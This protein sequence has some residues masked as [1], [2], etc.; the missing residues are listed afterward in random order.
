MA[1]H[2]AVLKDDGTIW[3]VKSGTYQQLGDNYQT[4][5]EA[6]KIPILSSI[7]GETLPTIDELKKEPPFSFIMYC[8]ES[9]SSAVKYLLNGVADTQLVTPA[10]LINTNAYPEIT[11]ITVDSVVPSGTS[12][13]IAVTNNL[14]KY[15]I[16]D[17]TN[18]VWTEIDI[19]EVKNLK[20]NGMPASDISQI[21]AKA[22]R[23]INTSGGLGFAFTLDITSMDSI[24]SVDGIDVTFH[25]DGWQK[26]VYGTDYSMV[27][28]TA[29]ELQV[30]LLASGDYKINYN[31]GNEPSSSEE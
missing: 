23:T 25:L 6:D 4:M 7:D 12:I 24:C 26:A 10:M 5:L 31:A 14:E 27:Y 30:A 22:W 13:S 15:Y 3:G 18:D 16:Y 11:S 1:K 2:V 19:S 17:S 21:P 28:T 9:P 8:D 29:D 20:E